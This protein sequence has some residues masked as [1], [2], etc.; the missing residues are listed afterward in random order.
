L[1]TKTAKA[2][3]MLSMRD[4]TKSSFSGL[5]SVREHTEF[6][7]NQSLVINLSK[8]DGDTD[9]LDATKRNGDLTM[10]SKKDLVMKDLLMGI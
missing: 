6:N 3:S 4:Q 7:K 5:A 2:Q 8:I 1:L 10:M 9:K